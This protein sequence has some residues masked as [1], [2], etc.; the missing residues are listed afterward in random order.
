MK[1]IIHAFILF[2][3]VKSVN[4]QTTNVFTVTNNSGTSILT[5]SLTQIDLTVNTNV[6][7]PWSFQW[8]GPGTSTT[9]T[10]VILTQSGTYTVAMMDSLNILVG[11]QTLTIT[12]NNAPPSGTV[13]PL[14]QTIT[15]GA[16]MVNVNSS[17]TG[18]VTHTFFSPIGSSF[19]V[20]SSVVNYST[21]L[22]GQY[23]VVL[24]DN[25]NGC[26][27]TYSFSITSNMAFPTFSLVSPQN[28]AL[29]CGPLPNVYVNI[30]NP[31]GGGGG[32][33]TF[34]VI[35]FSS[36]VPSG[37][38]SANTTYTISTIGSYYAVVRDFINQCTSQI[39]F[40]VST[41]TTGPGVFV[42]PFQSVVN[43]YT[44]Q[45]FIQAY[46]NDPFANISWSPSGPTAVTN[47]NSLTVGGYFAVP[48]N[49]IVGNYV[50]TANNF[51]T[52]CLSQTTITVYQNI[53]PPI[54]I[55]GSPS[56]V[57]TCASPS[58]ALTNQSTSGI[59]PGSPYPNNQPVIGLQWLSNVQPTGTLSSGYIAYSAD[60][61]TLMVKDPNNGCTSK[62]S[63][64]IIDSC[65]TVGIKSY[66]D[67]K[68]FNIFPNPS[69]GKYT[70]IS[71]SNTF[72]EILEVFN[73]NGERVRGVTVRSEKTELDLNDCP[74]GI[75]ILRM[76][77]RPEN[78]FKIIKQ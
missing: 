66:A 4:A 58:I 6:M 29:G 55:I 50:A 57:I 65:A 31:Q 7:P 2:L 20:N 73:L 24:H 16:P 28:F 22:P 51:A 62:T 11:I 75:Y 54:A 78:A 56:T 52:G 1:R 40:T 67:K 17:S 69:S 60:T 23:T 14:S 64:K 34:T 19:V 33:V 70:I 53:Y 36:F 74:S 35:P 38:L 49:S 15:C 41:N 39:P 76:K 46:S 37:N 30:V 68:S 3:V 61:Y 63:L 26:K 44:P 8:T 45:V 5:C 72:G 32:P 25:S 48:T 27:S 12:A 43:C 77:G 47:Q 59:P 71:Y 21:S 9:A 13:S 18:N 10:H 42:S